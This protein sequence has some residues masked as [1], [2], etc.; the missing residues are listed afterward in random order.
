MHG[1]FITF[2]G[3]DGCGKSLQAKRLAGR[4]QKKGVQVQLFRDPGC[5]PI[6][7]KVRRILLDRDHGDMSAMT[8]LLLYES[9]RAQLVDEWIRPALEKGDVVLCDR[10]TDSTLAYQGYGRGLDLDLVRRANDLACRGIF[11]GLTVVLDIP[12]EE[13]LRR[14]A[15]MNK[16]AD[17]MENQAREFFERVRRGFRQIA[18]AEPRRVRI[19]DGLKSEEELEQVIFQDVYPMIE[20]AGHH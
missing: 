2:E 12:V 1:L 19:L 7:E 20:S 3:I 14:M 16:P 17:R 18:E 11:P 4:L 10:F 13:S 8:E 15:G 9:A 5:P 6:S